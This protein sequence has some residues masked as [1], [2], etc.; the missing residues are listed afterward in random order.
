MLF[1]F[2]LLFFLPQL[3]AACLERFVLRHF[4]GQRNDPFS[5]G[6]SLCLFFLLRQECIFQLCQSAGLFQQLFLRVGQ[7]RFCLRKLLRLTEQSVGG[8]LLLFH[9]LDF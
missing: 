9:F 7:R 6:V 8:L 4:F 3:G 5:Q 2:K 1:F